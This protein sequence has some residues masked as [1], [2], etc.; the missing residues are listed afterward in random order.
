MNQIKSAMILAAGLGSRMAELTAKL[1]KPALKIHGSSFIHRAF[2]LLLTEGVTHVVVN[3][4][5]MADKLIEEIYAYPRLA[6]L[7]VDILFEPV[8]LETAGG[9]INALNVLPEN[10]FY[11]INGDV[12]Y[13]GYSSSPLLKLRQY[14]DSS[15]MD[16]VLLLN[17]KDSVFGYEGQGD[18]NLTYSI[19]SRCGQLLMS[20]NKAY[21]HAGLYIFNKKFFADCESGP[22]KMMEVFLKHQSPDGV[23]QKIYGVVNDGIYLHIGDKKAYYALDQYLIE[24]NHKL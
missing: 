22:R 6:S 23:L 5:Y 7:K 20:N 4:H 16:C 15:T 9:I 24:N 3:S 2:D 8:L 10:D 19:D 12:L 21:V 11:V 14:Y 17:S 18:F 1:P 13:T